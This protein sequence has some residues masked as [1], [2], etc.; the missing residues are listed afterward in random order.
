M[1]LRKIR[2]VDFRQ[3]YGDQTIEI[4]Q[5]GD[6][7]VTLIHA[8]NGVGKTTLLNSVLWALFTDTTARFEKRDQIVNFVARREGRDSARVEVEFDHDERRYLAVRE[9][10]NTPGGRTRGDFS[11][12]RYEPNGSLSPNLPNPELFV[13]SVIPRSMAPY[14]FFDGE[15]AETFASEKN[16]KRVGEAIRDILGCTLLDNAISDLDYIAR[17][18]DEELGHLEEGTERIAELEKLISATL[19]ER[20]RQQEAFDKAQEDL[21]NLE[22]LIQEANAGLRSAEAAAAL[23]QQREG[24]ERR[25][26]Q[27]E[28]ETK[29]VNAELLQWIAT[30]AIPLASKRLI[31]VADEFL[32]HESV[33]GRI[34]SPYNEEF[35]SKLLSAAQCICQRPLTP[36][37]PEWKAVHGMLHSAANVEGMNR[38]VRA[39]ARRSTLLESRADAPRALK[40]IQDKLARLSEERRTKEQELA[41]VAKKLEGS[42]E[43]D[44]Q[45]REAARAELLTRRDKC[46]DVRRD[47]QREIERLEAE[48]KARRSEVS[49]LAQK[50]ERAKRIVTRRDVALQAAEKIGELLRH[51]ETEARAEVQESVNEILEVVARKDF[52]FAIGE[53]FEIALTFSDGTPVPKSGGENQLMSLAFIAALIQF[54]EQRTKQSNNRL[55]IPATVAPLILDSPFGQLDDKYRAD[56]ARFVPSMAPQVVLLVS[57]S[58]GKAEV[59]KTLENRIGREYVLIAENAGPKGKKTQDFLTVRE[60][61]MATTLYNCPRDRTRIQ[62]ID[63]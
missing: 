9:I 3:F 14:F 29:E 19:K 30:R 42:S 62:E 58:Q 17:K 7:N 25:L 8:E 27:I 59:V 55:F 31:S 1:I 43:A 28:E 40:S 57:S 48:V 44:V 38:L 16:N 4:A 41:G 32:D 53:D 22:Q 37:S 39:R 45:R 63:E 18:F 54:A 11:V 47:A 24:V 34:P 26:L 60:Q 5:P 20:E 35:I 50:N 12:R 56:T 13:N 49:D 10:R 15:Q 23:Q 52:R 21:E 51:Y 36:D 6:Q 33:R 2:L 61:R 46:R